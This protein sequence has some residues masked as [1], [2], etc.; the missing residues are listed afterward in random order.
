[1]YRD[2]EFPRGYQP[3]KTFLT[4]FWNWSADKLISFVRWCDRKITYFH[5]V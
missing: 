3:R 2:M 5:D 1:M 4:P